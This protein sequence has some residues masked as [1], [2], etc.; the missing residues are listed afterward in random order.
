ME[1]INELP[2]LPESERGGLA[3]VVLWQGG[4]TTWVASPRRREA[5][6]A[7]SGDA[8]VLQRRGARRQLQPS[9]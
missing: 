6:L 1:R 9:F 5:I 4:V 3:T 7:S 2:S 8:L